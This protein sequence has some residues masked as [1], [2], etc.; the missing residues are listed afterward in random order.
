MLLVSVAGVTA[1]AP[2]Q[3]PLEQITTPGTPSPDSLF[4]APTYVGQVVELVNQ[5]RWNNGQL[6]PLKAV[7]L[8][9]TSSQTHSDNMA[10]RDFFAHCDPDTKT[11]PWDRMEAAGYIWN[12][13]GENIAAYYSDPAAV[14][15]GWMN[16]SGHRANILSTDFREIGVGYTYQSSD[17][18]NIRGDSNGDCT[19]DNFSNG[20]YYRYWV[21]N[22]GRRNTVYPVVINREAYE[23]TTPQVSLYMYGSGWAVEMR[24][25]NENGTWSAWQPYAANVNWTLSSGNGAKTVYAEIKN[26][27]GEVRSASDTIM[28][29][30]TVVEPIIGLAPDT[31]TVLRE[32]G[33]TTPQQITLQISN[34][35]TE[36]LNWS[37]AEQPAVGWV[38]VSASS[39]S[40]GGGESDTVTVTVDP[41]GMPLG[42]HTMQLQVSGNATN[43]PQAV[44]VSLVVSEQV[45]PVYL[46]LIMRD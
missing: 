38:A 9:H 29:N 14:M 8:L 22:F 33:S 2:T 26:G 10:N 4:A 18:G 34:G 35:G 17:Q 43:S 15:T 12:Y 40:I 7:D 37:I 6:P 30:V 32:T 41:Q 3:A 27:T 13:A 44:T 24:F 20:P 16:S 25:R 36:P 19:A 23:A 39:G 45:F 28:L 11:L 46:P 42:T 31:I 5:E 1:V 21:Q